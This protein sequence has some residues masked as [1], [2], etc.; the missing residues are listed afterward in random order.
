MALSKK[1][2]KINLLVCPM[3]SSEVSVTVRLRQIY[4]LSRLVWH[5]CQHKV[6]YHLF[7]LFQ[8]PKEQIKEVIVSYKGYVLDEISAQ[9]IQQVITSKN[10]AQFHLFLLRFLF[11]FSLV[12]VGL[13]SFSTTVN[14]VCQF[15]VH[16]VISEFQNFSFDL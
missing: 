1:I 10:T 3:C 2:N 14:L 15:S 13:D 12:M 4:E 7:K 6:K 9:I 5:S 16:P 8:Q 11:F